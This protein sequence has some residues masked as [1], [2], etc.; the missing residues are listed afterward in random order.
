M[1]SCMQ[2]AAASAEVSVVIRVCTQTDEIFRL[3]DAL[4]EQSLRPSE[5]VLIDSESAG[6]VRKRLRALQSAGG[7]PCADHAL[8]PLR[9]I[10]IPN[11]T[12]RSARALNQAIAQATCE[13]VAVISQ[14]ALP[15]DNNYLAALAEAFADEHVA[16]AYGRQILG[17]KYYPLGE[18]DLANTYPPL[19][20]TQHA[21]DCWFV[22]T[23]SMLR[24]S[25]WEKHPFDEQ[26]LI[27]EDHEW[28]KWAQAEGYALRYEAG[29]IVRHYHHFGRMG[30]LWK[31]HYLEG[32]GLAHIHDHSPG[33]FRTA[34]SCVRE[35]A[36]DGLW[37][38]RKGLVWHWPLSFARRSVKHAAL[39]CGHRK[40]I[41]L[42]GQ[43]QA[44][45]DSASREECVLKLE[46]V[47][48]LYRLYK[49]RPTT[50]KEMFVHLVQRNRVD[51]REFWALKGV[52]LDVHRGEI[53]GICGS[54]GSGK[55][56]LLR[57]IARILP[58][59]HGRVTIRGRISALLELSTGFHPELSGRENIN[60][61]AALLG[62][63]P[64]EIARKIDS[65][66][67]FA[68]LGE[69]IDCPV[70]TYS[71]GMYMRLGFS[72]MAHLEADILLIDEVLA[73][74]D[75]Q[76]QKKCIAWLY[77]LKRSGITVIIVSH[78]LGTL[79]EMC[80]RVVWLQHGE[81]AAD[82]PP[83]QVLEQYCPGYDAHKED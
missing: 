29:A 19:S 79:K 7:V 41:A 54:N 9:L 74:G 8:I 49:R 5:F 63:S 67:D 69:F 44:G 6:W 53:V 31:R 36:S 40:G 76:F 14:D 21:P 33:L 34:L 82:G 12:Y 71:A 18:K 60:L 70:K 1:S 35:I 77:E 30:E 23:C 51:Y 26:A 83:D 3:L 25:L 48:R 37:L 73:V 13:L 56:T 10:E 81:L 17:D 42:R 4:K 52:S 66:I 57:V 72:V 50:I 45:D 68:D 20:R 64:A 59:T 55:S 65:I 2:V 24:R 32:Q 58:A 43:A 46:H 78:D 15:A 62:F 47:W 11:S 28:G 22:N 27:S 75:A 80:D 38:L 16:G 39:Y 61:N